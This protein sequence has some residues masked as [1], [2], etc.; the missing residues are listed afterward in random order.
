M[1][2]QRKIIFFL[3]LSSS[4]LFRYLFPRP[5]R[6]LGDDIQTESVSHSYMFWHLQCFK[7]QKVHKQS[8]DLASLDNL[9][10]SSNW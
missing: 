8:R 2:K 9:R 6:K 1:G 7:N 3:F 10:P 5:T 4:S